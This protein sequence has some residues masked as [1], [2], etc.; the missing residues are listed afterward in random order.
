MSLSP[1]PQTVLAPKGTKNVYKVVGNNEKEN[2]T[3]LVTANAEGELAPTLILYALKKVPVNALKFAGEDFVIGVADNGYMTSKAFYEYIVNE[4][5]PWLTKMNLK[6][7]VIFYLDKHVSHLSL[8]L[9][10]FCEEKKIIIIALYPNTTHICQPLDVSLF[11]ALKAHYKN[12]FSEFLKECNVIE[13]NKYQLPIVLRRTFK[14]MDMKKNLVNGFRRCGLSPFNADNVD[15]TKCLYKKSVS[16]PSSPIDQSTALREREPS[17]TTSAE[18]SLVLQ[19]EFQDSQ[20][21]LNKKTQLQIVE[22]LMTKDQLACFKVN[23]SS[24]WNGLQKDSSLFDIWYKLTHSDCDTIE[25]DQVKHQKTIQNIFYSY[26]VYYKII[27]C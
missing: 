13:L 22:E 11:R 23:T 25:N 9:S 16:L 8:E 6:R 26:K 15:Y 19:T 3:V 5:E 1:V 21:K 27:F 4:F 20:L 24:T 18:Q 7:P 14:A 12:T 10:Q 17:P 2:T